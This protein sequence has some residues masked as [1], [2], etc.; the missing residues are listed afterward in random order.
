MLP[1]HVDEPECRYPTGF[2]LSR[3]RFGEVRAPKAATEYGT[4]SCGTS[5]AQP[6]VP[7][8]ATELLDFTATTPR[9]DLTLPEQPVGP[10][11]AECP[12]PPPLSPPGDTFALPRVGDGQ[13][14]SFPAIC[15]ASQPAMSHPA[16]F[17]PPELQVGPKGVTTEKEPLTYGTVQNQYLT[18]LSP[19]A[20]IAPGELGG[21]IAAP[22]R[23]GRPHHQSLLDFPGWWTQTPNT[24]APRSVEGVQIPSPSGFST[25]N[26]PTNLWRI[27]DPLT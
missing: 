17:A 9:S 8:R 23:S 24:W 11:P 16:P 2:S 25:N 19:M 14:D 27:D 18:K 20:P 6:D 1:Q 22:R 15:S 10:E 21:G 26:R 4:W 5:P 3:L 7:Q 13:M 12:V